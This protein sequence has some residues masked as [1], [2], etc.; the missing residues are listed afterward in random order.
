MHAGNL[1]SKYCI[2]QYSLPAINECSAVL[3]DNVSEKVFEKVLEKVKY[4]KYL[5]TNTFHS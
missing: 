3:T 4:F 1:L 2:N 5:N